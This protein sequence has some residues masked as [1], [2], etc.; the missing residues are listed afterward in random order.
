MRLLPSLLLLLSINAFADMGLVYQCSGIDSDWKFSAKIIRTGFS[1]T[2]FF[3]AIGPDFQTVTGDFN[4]DIGTSGGR[5][6]RGIT[7]LNKPFQF[8]EKLGG[9]F[10]TNFSGKKVRLD[11][12]LRHQEIA[13]KNCLVWF[14]GRSGPIPRYEKKVAESQCPIEQRPNNCI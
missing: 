11:C 1:T 13:V 4:Q 10:S 6:L 2:G 12:E 3:T 9:N 7:S 8:E 5:I 14:C